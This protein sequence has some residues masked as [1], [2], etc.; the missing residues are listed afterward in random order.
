MQ[1][2]PSETKTEAIPEGNAASPYQDE[3]IVVER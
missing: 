2:L 3:E 1:F